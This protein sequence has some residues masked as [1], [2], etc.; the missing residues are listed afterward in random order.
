M[1]G[2]DKCLTRGRRQELSLSSPHNLATPPP[3]ASPERFDGRIVMEVPGS[4]PSLDDKEEEEEQV[5]TTD[6]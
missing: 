4:S 1:P 6:P 2:R 5:M 3:S